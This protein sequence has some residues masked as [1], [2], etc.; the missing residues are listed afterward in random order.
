[1]RQVK[2]GNNNTP[3]KVNAAFDKAFSEMDKPAKRYSKIEVDATVF[4]PHSGAMREK[5]SRLKANQTIFAGT[6]LATEHIMEAVEDVV[7]EEEKEISFPGGKLRKI[8]QLSSKNNAVGDVWLAEKIYDDGRGSEL[9]VIKMLRSKEELFSKKGI[10]ELEPYE[11][12]LLDRYYKEAGEEIKNL[13]RFAENRHIVSPVDRVFPHKGRLVV[14]MEF[15]PHTLNDYLWNVDGEVEL[16]RTLFEA[17]LQIL[18][19][20]AYLENHTGGDAPAGRVNNDLKLGNMGADKEVR[21]DGRT[22]IVIKML[23]LDSI[24][25]ISDQL[26]IKRETKYSMDHCDP[27]QFMELHDPDSSLNAKPAE[28]IYSMAVAFMYALEERMSVNLK[29]RYLIVFPTEYEEQIER[30]SRST[31]LPGEFKLEEVTTNVQVRNAEDMHK[32]IEGVRETDELN[33]L[34]LYL[35]NKY[36]IRK[37]GGGDYDPPEMQKLMKKYEETII[38]ELLPEIQMNVDLFDMRRTSVN[39]TETMPRETILQEFRD[40]IKGFE[41]DE[42]TSANFGA[43]TKT[44]RLSLGIGFKIIYLT[45]AYAKSN[46]DWYSSAVSAF[47]NRHEWYGALNEMLITTAGFSR[48][49]AARLVELAKREEK[50]R[51]LE[52]VVKPEVFEAIAHC[53]KPRKYRLNAAQMK[54]LFEVRQMEALGEEV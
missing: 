51:K 54:K 45:E 25:P 4:M 9:V 43:V 16:S 42:K 24:R 26:S 50:G 30:F 49:E 19:T 46:Y 22:S 15:V 29:T 5:A 38:N 37:S 40:L 23:D 3:S 48:E 13:D 21:E 32:K 6:V 39:W 41:A 7:K 2:A 28:T 47:S 18:D 8:R 36:R 20:V 31:L 27:E 12:E 35:T 52:S 34:R 44:E 1:M 53:L 17:G 14:Q 11:K 10:D 33:L